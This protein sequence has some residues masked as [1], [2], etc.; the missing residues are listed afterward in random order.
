M[1]VAIANAL[2]DGAGEVFAALATDPSPGAQAFLAQLAEMIG[3]KHDD[4]EVKAVVASLR[5][6]PK[7]FPV[8]RALAEGASR[9]GAAD[10]VRDWLGDIIGDAKTVA[11]DGNAKTPE[12]IAAIPIV[13]YDKSATANLLDLL[14]DK[15]QSVQLAALA[16][17]DR[18]DAEQLAP[19]LV[20]LWPKFS[21]RVQNEAAAALLKRPD[22]AKVLLEAI[23]VKSVPPTALNSTQVALFHNHRDRALKKLAHEVLPPPASR[24]QVIES[25]KPS[26][27]LTGDASR[28]HAIYQKLCISCH[29]AGSEG[30]TLG[31]DF[32]TVRNSGREKLLLS[33]LDPN[34]EVR[35]DYIAYLIDTKEGASI[36]GVLASDTPTAI[37]VREAYSKETVI[38]RSNIKRMTSQGKTI[39]PEGLEQ[40]LNPQDLADLMT[41]IESTK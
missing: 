21:P 25:F 28:G 7:P 36:L 37:T 31:P 41:F 6:S 38:P 26:I 24:E 1:R 29:R 3:A 33:I 32:V 14:G 4:A 10:R 19:T 13:A 17:L 18:A 15:S 22:R 8:A 34:R 23:R 9:G 11:L 12:R 20:S 27:T 5:T 30:N 2:S 16:A 40:G 39:M 35:P